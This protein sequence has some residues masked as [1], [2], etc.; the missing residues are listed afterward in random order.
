MTGR[1]LWQKEEEI[2]NKTK[3]CFIRVPTTDKSAVSIHPVNVQ[4]HVR[5]VNHMHFACHVTAYPYLQLKAT[6]NALP[7]LAIHKMD[8][9]TT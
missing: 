4:K 2:L 5:I 1:I 3:G 9:H 7:G 6:P 8:F